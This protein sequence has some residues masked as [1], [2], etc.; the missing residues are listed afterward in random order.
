MLKEMSNRLNQE[1]EK[2]LQPKRIRIA[3]HKLSELGILLDEVD[4]TKIVFHFNCEKITFYPYSGWHTGKS[5]QDGRGLDNLLKQ[6]TV[7]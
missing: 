3:I 4:D 5:I 6:L 2:K 1:R 7:K